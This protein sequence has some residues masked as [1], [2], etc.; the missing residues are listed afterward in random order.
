MGFLLQARELRKWH[1]PL[2]C[3]AMAMAVLA[4]VSLMGLVVDERTL[5][6]QGVWLKPVKFA[7]SFGLYAITLAWM[8]GQ[9]G[10]WRRTQPPTSAGC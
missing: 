1:A 7:L 9:A 5:L 4:G 6:G 3:C 10:R 8:I 2:S